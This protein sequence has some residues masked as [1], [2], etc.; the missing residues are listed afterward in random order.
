MISKN[1]AQ[2]VVAVSMRDGDTMVPEWSVTLGN[3]Y[4][5]Q[6]YYVDGVSHTQLIE[7]ANT[8]TLIKRLVRNYTSVKYLNHITQGGTT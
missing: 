6:T 2:N 5:T 1:A 3:R 8:L 7:D 4:S